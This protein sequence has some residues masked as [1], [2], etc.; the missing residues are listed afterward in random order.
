MNILIITSL[1]PTEK[2]KNLPEATKAVHNLAKYWTTENRVVCIKVFRH[3]M[4]RPQRILNK[5][6]INNMLGHYDCMEKD[7]VEIYV[8]EY[9][10]LPMQNQMWTRQIKCISNRINGILEDIGFK[11]D[12]IIAHMPIVDGTGQYISE[13]EGQCPRIA[14]LHRSDIDHLNKDFNRRVLVDNFTTVF[15][16]GKSIYQLACQKN[17]SNLSREV[18]FSGVNVVGEVPKRCWGDFRQREIR[19]LYVGELIKRKAV[20]CIIHAMKRMPSEIKC[21]LYIVGDGTE[22]KNLERLVKE[23]NLQQKV[24]F[25]GKQSREYV[26]QQ[27]AF[28]D[29]FIM[30]SRHETLGLVYLEAM[31]MGCITIG[32]KNEG[33]DG[34]IENGKNGFLVDAFDTNGLERCIKEIIDTSAEELN[35][36]SVNAVKMAQYYNEFDM[37]ENY[38][39]LVKSVVK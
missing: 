19:F 27:M 13:V 25:L 39:K 4:I 3:T 35:E 5:S 16:R 22:K 12:V 32:S 26:D 20:D 30:I 21:S 15:T 7:G 38:L 18:I 9:C 34:I 8:I 11:P 29:I 37:A 6:C 23:N 28:A 10:M 36:I 24:F 33:I 2:K 17:I 14:V 31:R 1:Y